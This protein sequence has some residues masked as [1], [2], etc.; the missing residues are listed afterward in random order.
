[1]GTSPFTELFHTAGFVSRQPDVPKPFRTPLGCAFGLG[2]S[3]A[4]A[5][6]SVATRGTT[7]G[8]VARLTSLSL[9]P[10]RLDNDLRRRAGLEDPKP[11]GPLVRAAVAFLRGEG[12]RAS[13]ATRGGPLLGAPTR[14]TADTLLPP[15]MAAAC[16]S[17]D[18]LPPPPPRRLGIVDGVLPAAI[19][20]AARF[21][22]SRSVSS[23]CVICSRIAASCSTRSSA[24][25][26]CL[27]VVVVLLLTS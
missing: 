8:L 5:A 20:A 6:A 2:R 27:P 12:R 13:S 16:C 11:F 10:P 26:F 25:V 7:A 15:P 23:S 14:T 9:S 18:C 22:C 1:V 21:R 24:I 19:C 4:A 3:A 17:F